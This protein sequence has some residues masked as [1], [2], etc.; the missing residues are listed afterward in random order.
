LLKLTSR[1][2][3]IPRGLSVFRP[4]CE[5]AGFSVARSVARPLSDDVHLTL[6]T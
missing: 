1:A 5:R 4:L 6:A 2:A 3:T